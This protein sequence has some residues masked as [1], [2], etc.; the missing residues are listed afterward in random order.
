MTV[1]I[2]LTRLLI[3]PRI[4]AHQLLPCYHVGIDHV[5][6]LEHETYF[7][8]ATVFLVSLLRGPFLLSYTTLFAEVIGAATS[9]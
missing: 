1:V 2:T 4:D 7:S 3:P 5:P 6:R 8:F 9:N